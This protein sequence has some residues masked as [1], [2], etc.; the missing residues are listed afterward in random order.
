MTYLTELLILES[1][2]GQS[3][4][5]ANEYV[6]ENKGFTFANKDKHLHDKEL[7]TKP[8]SYFRDAFDRFAKNKGSIFATIVIGILVLY[9]IIAPIFSQYTVAFR[10][11]R[12]SAALPKNPLFA[13]TNFWD[14]CNNKEMNYRDFIYYYGI[15]EV[16]FPCWP[17]YSVELA[18]EEIRIL[19]DCLCLFR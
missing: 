10:D 16:V 6:I 5:K 8:K 15:G 17:T 14:G 7:V 2:W 9:A 11:D 4:M 12:Y 13:E 1:E 19:E 3:S 18:E